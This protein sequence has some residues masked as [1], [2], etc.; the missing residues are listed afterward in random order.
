MS[1]M[2]ITRAQAFP[3][4]ATAVERWSIRLA[5]SVT[6][7]ATRRAERRQ[8]RHEAMLAAIQAENTRKADPR[9]IEHLLAQVGLNGR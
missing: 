6:R 3:R 4:G 9:A 8:E 1:A 2:A 5:A 7:W